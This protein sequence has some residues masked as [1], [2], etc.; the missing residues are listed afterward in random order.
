MGTSEQE[1]YPSLTS[2][3]FIIITEAFDAICSCDAWDLT[4]EI[5]NRWKVIRA[6]RDKIISRFHP[7]LENT[8]EKLNGE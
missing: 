6:V 1:T 7:I 5:Q 4:V 3:E 8:K 2:D